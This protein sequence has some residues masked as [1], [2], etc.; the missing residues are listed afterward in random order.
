[1]PKIGKKHY[2]YTK[3]GKEQYRKD[4][5]AKDK[6][7]KVLYREGGDVESEPI[8]D[9]EILGI[10]KEMGSLMEGEEEVLADEK[11]SLAPEMMEEKQVP[12]EI[13][14]QDYI[15]Y[16]IG[17]SLSMEDEQYL[18]ERLEGDERLSTI[19]DRV[20]ETASEFSGAGSVE[21]PGSPVSD[22]IPARLSDGEFVMTS[23]AADEIGTDNLESLMR[24]AESE[25]DERR[26]QKQSGGEVEKVEGEEEQ[27]IVH[28]SIKPKIDP[29][30][31]QKLMGSSLAEKET[32]KAMMFQ[33]PRYSLF[34]S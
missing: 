9:E 13:M 12:D 4:M 17:E 29:Q 16:V 27:E 6:V 34:Q 10:D 26:L 3:E 31:Q 1:M 14:E 33:N 8:T 20:V 5:K 23:K 2:A 7:E 19:F 30:Q 25:A 22:S 21:G 24:Q 15:E 32:K 28:A 18:L 11:T